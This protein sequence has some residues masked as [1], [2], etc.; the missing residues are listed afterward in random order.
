MD[1]DWE[2][3]TVSAL[4]VIRCRWSIEKLEQLALE[5]H[6]TAVCGDSLAEER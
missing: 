1:I 2:S 3:I 5:G 4:T 6:P